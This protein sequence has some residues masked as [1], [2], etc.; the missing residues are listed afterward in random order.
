MGVHFPV[1]ETRFVSYPLWNR[2]YETGGMKQGYET[3]MKHRYETPSLKQGYVTR[4]WNRYE[5]PP[6]TPS[7]PRSVP[8]THSVS[9]SQIRGVGGQGPRRYETWYETGMKQ[10]WNI[11]SKMH[12]RNAFHDPKPFAK[13][14]PRA[15]SRRTAHGQLNDLGV[16]NVVWN[17]YET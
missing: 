1:Y 10:V 3:G 11:I 14:T 9:Q 5:T 8:S 13:P 2:G 17:M 4:V 15:A 12:Y 7:T 16:W 6:P